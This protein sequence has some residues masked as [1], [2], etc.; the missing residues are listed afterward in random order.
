[1]QW[2]LTCLFTMS[3]MDS[4]SKTKFISTF[5]FHHIA[6]RTPFNI[7]FAI[8]TLFIIRHICKINKCIILSLLEGLST[9][10]FWVGFLLAFN[11]MD[12]FAEKASHLSI[13]FLENKTI[14]TISSWALPDIVCCLDRFF[15]AKHM[16]SYLKA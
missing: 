8:C 4:T 13:S 7:V 5:A 16:K 12:K 3:S 2:A 11:T 9:C 15:E 6:S 1:M 10:Q 14:S